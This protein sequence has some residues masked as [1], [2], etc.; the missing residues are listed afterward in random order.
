MVHKRSSVDRFLLSP[1]RSAESKSILA[2]ITL[3]D[4]RAFIAFR[5]LWTTN[6]P[7]MPDKVDVKRVMFLLRNQFFHPFVRLLITEPLRN[8]PNSFCNSENMYVH[9]KYFLITR[10]QQDAGRCLRPNTRE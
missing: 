1:S 9:R 6:L 2:V 4:Q 8:Q 10:E 3:L 7:T 5:I